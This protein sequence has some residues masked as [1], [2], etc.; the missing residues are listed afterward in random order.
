[1]LGNTDDLIQQTDVV[2]LLTPRI[3]RTHELTQENLSPI[4]IGSSASPG[5]TGPT[6]V[7]AAPPEELGPAA[8][9]PAPP[10]GVPPA[11]AQPVPGVPP[12]SPQPTTPPSVTTTPGY[13]PSTVQP[14]TTPPPAPG[15]PVTPTPP[16]QPQPAA[17]SSY[18]PTATQPAP[19]TT[20]TPQQQAQAAQ[21]ATP[22]TTPAQ[23]SVS[24]PTTDF[25]VG[26][27]PYTVPISISGASRASIL[28]LTVTFNPATVRVRSVQEGT[29]MRQ[30]GVT[31]TFSQRVDP[32]TGRVDISVARSGDATGASGGGLLAA[33]IFDAIAP[34]AAPFAVS[35]V[36]TAPDGSPI[37]LAFTPTGASVK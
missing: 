5:L 17:P 1:V 34:G 28:S 35:G 6:P 23:V 27:G 26:G 30:G 22:P 7:I 12:V 21:Q 37:P 9:A 18:T 13:P 8:A 2:M 15:Q 25:R 31:P 10:G 36:A 29:F 20:Q 11:A 16:E 24:A 3:V 33:I 14:T 32:A 19:S 4:Y